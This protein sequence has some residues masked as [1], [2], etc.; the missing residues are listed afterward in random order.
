MPRLIYFYGLVV[1]FSLV[2]FTSGVPIENTPQENANE[3]T[4]KTS[5]EGSN[6]TTNK[7]SNETTTQAPPKYKRC[8]CPRLFW[9][10]CGS[11]KRIYGNKCELEC[12]INSEYGKG[13]NL[14]REDKGKYKGCCLHRTNSILKGINIFSLQHVWYE[15]YLGIP[16]VIVLTNH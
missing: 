13:I 7:T 6:D 3:T 12:A 16:G 8:P 14:H 2:L 1:L 15:A 5:N 11:D 10:V 9:P 4:N